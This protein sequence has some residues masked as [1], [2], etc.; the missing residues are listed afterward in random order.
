MSEPGIRKFS[1]NHLMGEGYWVWLIPLS[2]G[3][4]SIGVCADPRVHPFEEINE[5]ERMVEWLAPARAPARG[6]GGARASTTSRT[7]YESRTSPTAWSGCSRPTAGRSSGEAGAF[8]DPFYSPG[9]D[10]IGYGNIFTADLIARDLDGEDVSE[11]AEAYNG[12]FIGLFEA[13]LDA[14]WNDH[15]AE[16]G[17]AEVFADKVTYDYVAYWGTQAP[18]E[19]YDKYTDAEFTQAVLPT[20]RAPSRCPAGF[21]SCCATGT[22]SVRRRTRP[23]C[24]RSRAPSRGCGTGSRELKAGLDE[25]TLR[26]RY[27]TN[28]D[29]LEGMAVVYFHKA[30]RRLAGGPPDPGYESTRTLSAF[31]RSVGKRTGCSTTRTDA[32]RGLRPCAGAAK[33]AARR[34][35][36]RAGLAALPDVRLK[37]VSGPAQGSTIPL[38]RAPLAFGRAETGVGTLGGDPELSRSHARVLEQ[39]G[40]YVLED[41][42]VD[43]RHV[44]ERRSDRGP[45]P[46]SRPGTPSSWAHLRWRWRGSPT[47]PCSKRWSGPGA[48]LRLPLGPEPLG[49]AARRRA[50]PV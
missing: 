31:I 48:G 20:W 4:I 10:M 41:L 37:I 28:V 9:S 23:A 39:D 25:E 44:R 42:D 12:G 49:S 21:S 38:G 18:R 7:S 3:P 33:H 16:F 5:L 43:Q 15:Y 13:V 8:A 34:A 40:R 50:M 24:M 29:I 27:K 30:C 22:R 45:D 11:L 35:R 46:N 36:R 6:G 32:R 26:A 17:D 1:T 14:V 47:A 2:S 19:Y